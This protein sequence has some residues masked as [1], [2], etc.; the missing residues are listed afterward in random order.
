[1]K[2]KS[3]S[4]TQTSEPLRPRLLRMAVVS[5]LGLYGGSV[6]S[7][8]QASCSQG[9]PA[10]GSYAYM[11]CQGA[12]GFDGKSEDK[13]GVDGENISMTTTADGEF[14]VNAS[15]DLGF[16]VWGNAPGVLTMY[17]HGGDGV[18]AADAGAGGTVFLENNRDVVLEGTDTSHFFRGL[19]SVSSLGGRADSDNRD[20]NSDG[21][22]GGDGQALTITNTGMLR[23]DGTV[24]PVET[25]G[26][27]F[28]I[29]AI[30]GG[31]AGGE[32]NNPVTNLGQQIGGNGGDGGDITLT[33]DGAINIGSASSRIT[34]YVSTAGI[35][36][37]SNG[38]MGGEDNGNGG[39]GGEIH[40]LKSGQINNVWTAENGNYAFGIN[41]VSGGSTGIISK[42]NSD[43]GGQGGAGS[44]VSI[45]VNNGIVVD[46]D[47]AFTGDGAGVNALSRGGMGGEGPGKNKSGGFGG[48]GGRID[49]DLWEGTGHIATRGDNL[50]GILAQSIGGEG[51]NGGDATALAGEGG[52][53]GFGGSAGDIS[54]TT[55]SGS[56]IDTTGNFAGGIV[57]Q[58]VGGG[59]GTGG[60]F[61][62]VL[63]GQS[64]NGGNGG[65]GGHVNVDSAGDITT[66]GEHAYGILAQS[67]AGSGGT[68]GVNVSVAVSLGGD[69]AGGGLAND[70][71]VS[72]SGNVSTSGYSAHGIIAQSIG[73]GGGASG[74]A[75]GLLSIGG[76]AAGSTGSQGGKITVQN[77][78]S[79][80]TLGDG[81][82]G[83]I[84]Q[85]IG[86]G[87]GSGGDSIGVLGVGGDGAAGGAGGRVVLHDLGTI[88]TSGNYSAGVLAQS[89]GGGGGNGGDTFTASAGVSVAIGGSGTG[90]G[91]GGSL[92]MGNAG[93]CDLQAPA[94]AADLTTHGDYS[95]GIIAQN[96]GGGGG[97]G[98]SV[99]NVSVASF[100][101]LQMGGNAGGGGKAGAEGTLID[102]TDLNIKTGGSHAT[103]ILAQSIGGG[104]GNGGDSTYYNV[105]AGFNAAV[106]LGGSGGDGG[107]GAKTSVRLRNSHIGTGMDYDTADPETYAPND[108]F[109]ILAQTIGGGG[110]NG[111]SA[112]ASALVIA[113]PPG[114]PALPPIAI[115]FAMAAGGSG[116]SGGDACSSGDTSC[117]TEVVLSDG[118]SVTTLGDG[119]HAIV[120]QSI[121][122]GGGNGGDSSVMTAGIGYGD[123]VSGT[124][125]VSLGGSGGTASSG[126]KVFIGLGNVDGDYAALPPSLSEPPE[127]IL[128]PDSSILTYGDFANGVLAQ[129]IGGGGG[130]GGVGSSNA[131]SVGG[132]A[133]VALSI[134]LGGAG[135]AGGSGGQV[136]VN[137]KPDFTIHTAGSGSRAILAQSIGGGGGASQGGTMN[138]F[139]SAEGLGGNLQL[140]V[141]QTGGNGGAG[142]SVNA[143]ISGAIRTEGGDADG[144]V[145]Q[146]IGGGGGVGGSIGADSSSNPILDRIG[147]SLRNLERL[148]DAGASYTFAVDIGGRGGLGGAGGLVDLDFSGKIATQGDWA[149]GIV[150]QSIG[151][152]GGAGGSSTA[153]G[154]KVKAN[155]DIAIGGSGGVGG[156]GGTVTAD[157]DGSYYNTI[158]TAGY[159]A[160]GVLLQSIG[161]GGGQGGD[162]SDMAKGTLTIGGS[163][164]GD[165]GTSGVGGTI[166]TSDPTSWVT[167]KTMGSD[168][169]AFAAQSIGGG[170]GIGGVGNSQ[171]GSIVESHAF[172][173]SVGGHGGAGNHG[174]AINL[175]LGTDITTYGDRSYGFVAQSIGGGGGIGGAGEASHLTSVGLGG[176]AGAG[177][178]GGTVA[179][180]LN[181]GS[182]VSTSGAGAHAI[183]AQSIG[184]GGGI[185][186]DSSMN[187]KLRPVS[188]AV[189]GTQTGGQGN[190]GSVSIGVDGT[191]K[192]AGA[193][194]FGILAQSIGGGGGLG[195]DMDGGY[196]GSTAGDSGTGSGG[197]VTV[198]QTGTIEA[199]GSGSTGI[200]AQST[201]P[202]GAGVITVNVNGT[203]TGGSGENASSVWIAGGSNNVLN[204]GEN[205]LINDAANGVGVRYDDEGLEDESAKLA[206][207]SNSTKGYVSTLDINVDGGLYG[208]ILCQNASSSS[209]CN[210]G[211]SDTGY[212][213]NA[214][215]YQA[216]I[217][218][219]GHIGIGRPGAYDTLTV[220]GNYV[221]KDS[222]VLRADVDFSG[223]QA[224][225]LVVQGDAQL[226]GGLD[227]AAVSLLPR[228]ELT[229]LNVQGQSTGSLHAI[230]SPIFDFQLRQE[231]N[232]HQVSVSNANFDPTSQGLKGNQS[233]VAKHLQKIWNLGGTAE[234]GPLFAVLNQAA[235]SGPQAY[236]DRL[237]DL[238]PGV[239]LAPAGQ[240]TAGLGRFMGG[241]MSCPEATGTSTSSREQDCFWGQVTRR[242]TDHDA[243]NGS[244]GFSFDTTTYQFGGQ[245]EFKP[246]WFVGGSVAY[247]DSRLQ[248]DTGRV[249]GNGD[250]GYA[251]VVLKHQAGPWVYSGSIAGG[252]GSFK[253]NRN[254]NID[255]YEHGASS[256]PDVY[257]VGARLRA[258]R[259]IE[260]TEKVYLKPYVDL[261]AFYTRMPGYSESG[262]LLSLKVDS[263]DQFVVG[264]SPML[265]IGGRVDLS[266]G[267]VMR[268]YAYAGAS[269]LSK[270]SWRATAHL[271]GAP[272]GS[273]GMSTS[274]AGDNVIGR[275]GLGV[276][277][278]TESG[279][280]FRLQYDGEASS[281]ST[282][283]AG[284]L[285]VMYRF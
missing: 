196:A 263:S 94:F 134:G 123:S 6:A 3:S 118:S 200:F 154:S 28:G 150:A 117:V 186:G 229:V 139:A 283:H 71:S 68:G 269:F 156:N 44:A 256:D 165:G 227:L 218:N 37:A 162:G 36:A 141:G 267:A 277:V 276:Q 53:A 238:S 147:T 104:G 23:V 219:A 51:G 159:S 254:L 122:G 270:D 195:G 181:K 144:V 106:V 203:V 175:N 182:Y 65:D 262:G 234:L 102:Y 185:A 204:V 77:T 112:S 142:G 209:G 237:T 133:T 100:A 271:A 98:G 88:N 236:R 73:G 29:S 132:F 80:E 282:S 128:A 272:A 83:I 69:G 14:R 20:N 52:G 174:G 70:V 167:I 30:S 258:A 177:G 268:P 135:G 34:G 10:D 191:I 183:M 109:G 85:S 93:A 40:I 160:Y 54:I 116:G 1:M 201:G 265:E 127:N 193:Q 125:G 11:I 250:A 253:L 38:G 21:G 41:A 179:L 126:G 97:N 50:Y 168:A 75:I 261:D 89:I 180:A 199:L 213:K 148:T 115:N 230:D 215:L 19:I 235:N 39:N 194:S 15:D 153:S 121:G 170:G 225:R 9:Q 239:A 18:D 197:L 281:K 247:Q 161:G 198:N 206:V 189:D 231:G 166:Q 99:K 266:N 226:D 137:L 251:G 224:D 264:L 228:R 242:N 32:Q 178:D 101:A 33:N 216:N 173:L 105:T 91:D 275:F 241:M 110:G 31:G 87:G 64:G 155:V 86:G 255:G 72:Q 12:N 152:G 67:I 63:G 176:R 57:A 43:N 140:G 149:D 48:A 45:Q 108:S 240:M 243:G 278:N 2:I 212:M 187:I 92:C 96:I 210:V 74:S 119:S 202:D 157:F 95:P 138:L 222:G 164:G 274:L 221:Q 188:W 5:A 78:G 246:D 22:N 130:N 260:L 81:A 171:M 205:G 59:G 111:G 273:T 84:A 107:A 17:T 214:V 190:G 8:A 124:L 47:G 248:G 42:D 103:G 24:K 13:I 25:N 55:G 120:A 66:D 136:D 280:D 131:Y 61:V 163:A 27:L 259:H 220:T 143:D 217:D 211:V 4:C 7:Y 79:L 90:G 76:S 114:D 285:K 158:Q 113:V 35:Q 207:A 146:S 56:T 232:T 257:T 184:G 223:M 129:S 49:V 26:S 233:G 151:G 208:N 60:L 244:P 245:R 58:S 284:Q 172:V 279:F 252:Y 46:I 82:A 169:P 249:S 145:L 16:E 62:A 192:T